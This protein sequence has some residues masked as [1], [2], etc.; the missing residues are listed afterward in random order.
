MMDCVGMWPTDTANEGGS[1]YENHPIQVHILTVG[2][3]DLCKP[4]LCL[5]FI[6][7][8]YVYEILLTVLS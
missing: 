5:V 6:L 8:A 3:T 1:E 2:V 7:W 4:N